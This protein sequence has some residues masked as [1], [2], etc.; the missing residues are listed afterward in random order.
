MLMAFAVVW[1]N[2]NIIGADGQGT[3]AL[4][5]LGILLMVSINNLLGGGGVIY[6]APRIN[7]NRLIIPCFLWTLVSVALFFGIFYLIPIVPDEYIK[8]VVILGGIQS[9]FIFQQQLLLGRNHV[10]RFNQVVFVQSLILL[11]VLTVFYFEIEEQTVDSYIRA[12]YWSFISTLAVSYIA[13]RRIISTPSIEGFVTTTKQLFK[14]GFYT[15]TSNIFQLLIN[16]M[17]LLFLEYFVSR[18]GVGIFSVGMLIQEGVLAPSKSVATVQNSALVNSRES[19]K[20]LSLT[21]NML[22]IS[23]LITVFLGV[24]AALI[25][26][27]IYLWVFGDEMAGLSS[28]IK[29]LFFGMV[30]MGISGIVAHHFS[31]T[32]RHVITAVGSSI[33]LVLTVALG[34]YLIPI[35]GLIAAAWVTSIVFSKFVNCSRH[36]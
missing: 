26:E 4:I 25:P 5:S 15:Q 35:H 16:R 7:P 6:L 28:V 31:G 36:R 27:S 3:V 18:S 17:S 10:R 22:K 24:I 8:D 14:Y 12:L 1:L 33:A 13:N 32:G 34:W 23:I 2:T 21:L 19:Q 11:I 29:W 9:L 30:G 20:N